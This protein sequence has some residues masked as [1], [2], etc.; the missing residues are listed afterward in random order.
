MSAEK[1][2]YKQSNITWFLLGALVF[3][4]SSLPGMDFS[5][6][7]GSADLSSEDIDAKLNLCLTDKKVKGNKSA[8]CDVG[9][10]QVRATV[11]A[12]MTQDPNKV[13][14]RTEVE[15]TVCDEEERTQEEVVD[16][17]DMR[18]VASRLL[19]SQVKVIKPK[20]DAEKQRQKREELCL[21]RD[22]KALKGDAVLKCRVER[23]TSMNEEDRDEYYNQYIKD[24]IQ[25][26]MA[27]DRPKAAALLR[28]LGKELN[29]N[30]SALPR[31]NASSTFGS[32]QNMSNP[33]APMSGGSLFG[34]STSTRDELTSTEYIKNSVCDYW[35]YGSY[36]DRLETLTG[37]INHPNVDRKQVADAIRGLKAGWGSYFQSRGIALQNDWSDLGANLLTD[38]RD[39]NRLFEDR[40]KQ[41]IDQHKDL[42]EP[43][44]AGPNGTSTTGLIR[45]GR[46]A[47]GGYVQPTNSPG[48]TPVTSLNGGNRV[49]PAPNAPNYRP[50][51]NGTSFGGAPRMGAPV[52]TPGM[53]AQPIRR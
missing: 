5:K 33:F 52:G 1:Q 28:L 26:L 4:L 22:G 45:D 35:A 10:N 18:A 37:M 42:L 48:G 34:Q 25:R 36:R 24:E 46:G 15:C 16:V 50:Q 38:L 39:D 47:R 32:P 51:P 9:N 14:V 44:Y 6:T 8:R 21:E 53:P 30:C 7:F 2:Q 29:L 19:K 40:Y 20:E 49:M 11:T 43:R 17:R 41:V 12:E 31:Y 13:R 23:L 27:T 3:S